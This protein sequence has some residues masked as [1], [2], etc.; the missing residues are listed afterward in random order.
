[1]GAKQGKSSKVAGRQRLTLVGFAAL[2]IL[3]FIGF[4]IAQGVGEPSVPSG[5][6][7]IVEGVP[8]ELGTISEADFKRTLLH[9]A[10]LNNLKKPPQPGEPKYDELKQA[11]LEELFDA[12]W[13]EGQAEEMGITVTPKQIAT[14][15]AQIKKQNFKT[16]AAYKEFLKTSR[17]TQE[18]VDA[19]V[20]TQI[21]GTQIQERIGQESPPPSSA[22]VSA[23]YDSVKDT[24]FTTAESRDIR[25]VVN[26]DKT[27]VEE[28]KKELEK[29]NSPASWKK[30]AAKFS[31]DPTTKSKGGLQPALSEELLKSQ[32][33][34][35]QAV[36]G[37]PQSEIVGPVEVEGNFFVLEVVT[38]NPEKVQ[39]L[40]EVSAQIKSQL[41]Q[42]AQ[43]EAFSEFVSGYQSKWQSRTLCA[44]GFVIERCANY[45]ASRPANA[46]PACYE[47]DPKGGLPKD[48]PAPVTQPAPALPGSTTLLKPQGERLPQR[49]RPEGIKAAAEEAL[50]EGVPPSTGGAAAPPPPAG[51]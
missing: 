27:K 34:L 8:D 3:L 48:C 41:A 45:S 33:T 46:P 11:A 39:S 5:D 15:L 23:Y 17:F 16:D 14:E 51:E 40:G 13:I 26:K 50:P 28:A 22:Q 1:V 18:E 31:N 37:S 43:Q 32:P 19:R 7:A 2:F 30:V 49:P 24:Q 35:K 42:Q 6:V 4:A 10:G 38:L 29:D 44:S 9:Q 21:L 47:A 20:K 25:A 12:I 36:F